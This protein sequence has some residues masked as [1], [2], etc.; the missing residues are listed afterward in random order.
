LSAAAASVAGRSGPGKLYRDLP[1]LRVPADVVERFL[2]EPVDREVLLLAH[3]VD[4]GIDLEPGADVR[5]AGVP[6][7]DDVLERG[8]Q[9][10]LVEA[11]RPEPA[12]HVADGSVHVIRDVDDLA[13][14]SVDVGRAVGGPVA[15]RN[16]IDLDR[17]Q[18]LAQLVVQ[19]PRELLA[20]LFLHEHVRERQP[21]V[22]GERF[23]EPFLGR[24]ALCQLRAGF[25]R[26]APG[27]PRQRN[28][29][30]QQSPG[31]LVELVALHGCVHA[32]TRSLS[33]S[34]TLVAMKRPVTTPAST[35]SRRDAAPGLALFIMDSPCRSGKIPGF[36]RET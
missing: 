8:G 28:G 33:S 34:A 35:R 25:P 10:E 13:R 15:Y 2:H 5:M 26:P 3:R 20:F 24:D 4:I 30:E 14:R 32:S 9:A 18:M 1:G 16:G 7:L 29:E 19:L 21:A 23:G 31:Q 27:E 17:V 11:N 6:A 22:L 36:G 12:Q